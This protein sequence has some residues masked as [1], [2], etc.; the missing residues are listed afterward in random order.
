[1]QNIVNTLIKMFNKTTLN[2]R[3][4]DNEYIDYSYLNWFI[5]YLSCH[6]VAKARHK[7]NL[8]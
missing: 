2:I 6:G 3:F 1:M 8:P 5:V 7:E 4:V